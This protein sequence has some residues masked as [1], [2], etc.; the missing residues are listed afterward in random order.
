MQSNTVVFPA[1][2]RKKSIVSFRECVTTRRRLRCPMQSAL[3]LSEEGC[4]LKDF[5]WEGN[6]K[7]RMISLKHTCVLLSVSLPVI[8]THFLIQNWS[9]FQSFQQLNASRWNLKTGTWGCSST[10]CLLARLAH[11]MGQDKAPLLLPPEG[12][13]PEPW[14]RNYPALIPL[15]IRDFRE[16]QQC[17][18][19][20]FPYEGLLASSKFM[21]SFLQ[22]LQYPWGLWLQ[23]SLSPSMPSGYHSH[24]APFS[25]SALQLQ[26]GVEA[27][28]GGSDLD[29]G[30]DLMLAAKVSTPPPVPSIFPHCTLWCDVILS[31]GKQL[32]KGI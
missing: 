6:W 5:K 10:Q 16:I 25:R 2:V 29:G 32:R 30:H 13:F 14:K 23:S 3:H 21:F 4:L 28:S 22:S 31:L 19:P 8:W 17:Y 1:C 18:E 11:Q 15:K 27:L 9:P 24:H 20:H 12:S 7:S 26:K